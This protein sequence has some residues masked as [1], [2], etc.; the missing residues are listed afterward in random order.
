M[1]NPLLETEIA[2]N[3]KLFPMNLD[4]DFIR[5]TYDTLKEKGFYPAVMPILQNA[6]KILDTVGERS[7]SELFF[8]DNNDIN[9]NA[10]RYDFTLPIALHYLSQTTQNARPEQKIITKGNVFRRL[11]DDPQ[12]KSEFQQIGLEFIGHT[13]RTKTDAEC[14]ATT[15]DMLGVIKDH[16]LSIEIS[17]IGLSR[18]ICEMPIIPPIKSGRLRSALRHRE[19]FMRL[20]TQKKSDTQDDTF[21][22]LGRLDN[23]D[24]EKMMQ[25]IFKLTGLKHT[26]LR[27]PEEITQR[28]V[29]K[30]DEFHEHELDSHVA[31]LLSRFYDLEC[32]AEEAAER[33]RN[34]LSE[35]NPDIDAYLQYYQ[36]RL[37]IL[38]SFN[39][40]TNRLIYGPLVKRKPEYYSGFMFAIDSPSRIGKTNSLA[41]GGRYDDLFKLLGVDDK[42]PAVG[43]EIRP[44]EI[45]DLIT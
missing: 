1:D 20:L 7:R 28:F 13:E 10:L 27:N 11:N 34:L 18:A 37:D 26:G 36:R 33:I 38:R 31:L 14:L 45:T 15:L 16:P 32:P 30:A 2:D 6:D 8:V 21:A 40:D 24:A 25:D 41:G 12:K 42:I 23:S 35:I 44:S 29:K 5:Q 9:A 17:D 39:V 43:A 19:K 4:E 3:S 22:T